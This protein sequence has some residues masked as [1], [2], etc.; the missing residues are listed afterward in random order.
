MLTY[1]DGVS[2]VNIKELI[3]FHE[4]S[5]KLVTLT[6]VKIPGRFGNLD[7]DDAGTVIHFAEKPEGDGMW[8]NG[9]FFVMETDVFKYLDDQM[10]SIQ[11]EKE[12]LANIAKDGQLAAYRHDGFWKCM[13]A[14]RDR[15]ELEDM[16]NGGKAKWKIWG[17]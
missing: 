6:S 11:L 8:I 9:G 14:L 1:G 2:N 16:W 13:D 17:V 12:P 7:T 5:G 3:K 10:D 4:Q 15:V